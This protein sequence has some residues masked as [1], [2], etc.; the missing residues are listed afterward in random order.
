MKIKN[1]ERENSSKVQDN[2]AQLNGNYI[3]EIFNN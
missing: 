3:N 2:K 1:K